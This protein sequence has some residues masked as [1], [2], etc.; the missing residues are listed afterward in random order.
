MTIGVIGHVPNPTVADAVALARVAETE[1]AHWIGFADAFWWRDVWL[2]L[3]EVARATERIEVGPG[4]TNPYLRHPFHTVS[5]LATL[6]EMAPGRVGVG[7]AAGGSEVT[8]AAGLSRHD[9]ATRIAELVALIRRVGDGG[10]LDPGTGKPLELAL[11]PLPVL[12]AGRGDRVLATAGEVAD[13]VLLWSVP[14]SDLDRSVAQVEAGIARRR[15]GSRPELVW[16]PLV[17]LGDH[18]RHQVRRIAVYA[19]IN[20][21]PHLRRRW[22]LS[23]DDVAAIRADLV[24]GAWDDAVD[25]VPERAI[26]DLVHADADPDVVADRAR[27]IGATGIA[28]PGFDPASLPARVRWATEVHDRLR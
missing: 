20:G 23:P 24:R 26:A 4:M 25:R 18:D 3:G 2:L 10:P 12:V 5:A 22:G 9:A 19:S 13:R 1:G 17:A 16:A 28:V 7:I 6:Q 8:G 14:D 11:R 21:A 27:R 15:D